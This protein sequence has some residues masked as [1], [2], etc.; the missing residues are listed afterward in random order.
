MESGL[1]ARVEVIRQQPV[2][3]VA[4]ILACMDL[5][6]S[7]DTGIMHVAAAAGVPVLSLFGPT[8]PRQWAPIDGFSRFIESEGGVIER[9]SLQT[10]LAVAREMLGG[11]ALAGATAAGGSNR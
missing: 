8:D 10:A 3:L 11:K 6:V 2:R 4:S 1:T 5:V 7:N 9:I